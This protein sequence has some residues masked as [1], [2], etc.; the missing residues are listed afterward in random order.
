MKLYGY[1]RSSSTWRVRI[2]LAWKGI[3]YEYQPIHLVRGGGE[4]HSPSYRAINPLGEVPCLEV[5]VGG[6]TRRLSQSVAIIELLEQAV[7]RPPLFPEDPFLTARTR[8][9]VEIVNSGTQPLQ[10]SGVLGRVKNELHADE[11]AW[12]R[13]F[14][15]RGLTALE[16]LT[17][18]T[19]G[20]YSVGD[21]V[22]AADA[23]L[24]PQLY[25]A[26]RFGTD[27]E[28][29]PRLLAIEARCL[30]LPPF[31]SS[32]PDRQPDAPAPGA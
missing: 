23:Y 29:F 2:A 24:V 20:A 1:W 9:L 27:L 13:H 5:E 25:N 32:H 22:T 8:Q 31:T 17:G 19:A 10:N 3:A 7:P 18:E 4:Q 16:T 6:A 30:A 11:Q 15:T 14:I 21:Q 26:R 28:P 12:A